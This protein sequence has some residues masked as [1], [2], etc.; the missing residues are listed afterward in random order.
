MIKIFKTNGVLQIAIIVAAVVAIWIGAFLKP[1]EMAEDEICGPVYRLMKMGL[2]E[3]PTV[4]TIV[5][6]LLTLAEGYLLNRLLYQKGLIPLNTLM[7]TLLYV[8]VMG[9]G[10]RSCG[11]TPAV[12]ANLWVVLALMSMM[13]KENM[14]MEE[15]KIFNTGL[16]CSMALLTWMPAVFVLVPIVIG[17]ITYKMYKGREWAVNILGLMAPIIIVLTTLFM[18]DK[19]GMMAVYAETLASGLGLRYDGGAWSI[20]ETSVMGLM[21]IVTTAGT[22]R[23]LFGRT[24]EQ[25]KHG[26]VIVSLLIFSIASMFYVSLMPIDG[27]PYAL[28]LATTGSIFLMEKK[29]KLWIYDIIIALLFATSLFL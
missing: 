15:G 10:V 20:V 4:S 14:I 19:L 9:M 6:L 12:V 16:W 1:I 7:P 8:I 22:V 29:K 26:L 5:A 28:V 13:P 21:V 23:I 24:I 25:R 3:L 17:Q 11:L 18:M 2:A 27:G